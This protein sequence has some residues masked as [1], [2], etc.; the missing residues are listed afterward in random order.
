MNLG[1]SMSIKRALRRG[2]AGEQGEDKVGVAVTRI[3]ELLWHGQYE[4][5]PG[6]PRVP[7]RGDVSLKHPSMS[8]H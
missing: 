5:Y 1:V 3:L 7:V 2:E 8:M 6:G 4:A